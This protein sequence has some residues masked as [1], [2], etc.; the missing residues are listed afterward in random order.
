MQEA[1]S[2]DPKDNPVNSSWEYRTCIE[3]HKGSWQDLAQN[4]DG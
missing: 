1:I 3:Y 2:I 4:S